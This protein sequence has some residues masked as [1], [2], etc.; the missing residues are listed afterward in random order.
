MGVKK[1]YYL[2]YAGMF[3]ILLSS[4]IMALPSGYFPRLT[5]NAFFATG[6]T[7]GIIASLKYWGWLIRELFKE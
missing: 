3:F 1:Y 4:I 2:Y 7:L 6:L 5:G